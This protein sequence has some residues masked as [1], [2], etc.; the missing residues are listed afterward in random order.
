[1]L[2]ILSGSSYYYRGLAVHGWAQGCLQ[3]DTGG[4]LSQ[5]RAAASCLYT[6]PGRCRGPSSQPGRKW[7]NRRSS[8]S[9]SER[10]PSRGGGRERSRATLLTGALW[11]LCTRVFATIL[12]AQLFTQQ[13]SEAARMRRRLS[14]EQQRAS[15]SVARRLASVLFN[16]LKRALDSAVKFESGLSTSA[17]GQS[18]CSGFPS[19]LLLFLDPPTNPSSSFLLI[20]L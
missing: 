7:A 15:T 10:F 17:V 20:L 5:L 12:R 8:R 9:T 4:A 3:T 19:R 2:L 13:R 16:R 1:L 14:R 6:S 18:S 11:Y